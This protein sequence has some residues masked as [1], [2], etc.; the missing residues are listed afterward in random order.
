MSS[1]SDFLSNYF[2]TLK[3]FHFL[4]AFCWMAGLFY[5][6]RLFV[7]HAETDNEAVRQTLDTMAYKLYRFIM[8]PAMHLT[9]LFGTMLAILPHN[10]IAGWLHLKITCILALV[11]FQLYLNRCRLSLAAR[12][13]QQTGRYF[14]YIN[15]IPTIALIIILI[16][17][18][19]KPF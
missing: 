8:T 6:P 16:C 13:S 18:V 14:R 4:G 15:E 10:R 1:F 3:L 11:V 2:L 5:L 9:L 17:A 12:T 7:Y 19:F